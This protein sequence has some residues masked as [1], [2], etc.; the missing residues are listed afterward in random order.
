MAG[1]GEGEEG[2]EGTEVEFSEAELRAL[3]MQAQLEAAATAAARAEKVALD[4][5]DI[6][7]VNAIQSMLSTGHTREGVQCRMLF[8]GGTGE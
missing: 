4:V 7:A 2:G 6:H 8:M 3:E 1:E 5:S